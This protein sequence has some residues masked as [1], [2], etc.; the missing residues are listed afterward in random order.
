MRLSELSY[1]ADENI[2]PAV[3]AFLQLRGVDIIAAKE[4]GLTG[5]E[6]TEILRV[7]FESGR[8]VLSHD[9]DC[10]KLAIAAGQSVKGIVYLRPGHF[11]ANFTNELLGAILDVDLDLKIPFILVAV[12]KGDLVRIRLRAL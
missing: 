6:D 11:N 3:V 5:A 10:G 2:D 9:S 1:L 4:C 8:A 7:A 12:R